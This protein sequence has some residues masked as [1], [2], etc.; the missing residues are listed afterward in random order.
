MSLVVVTKDTRIILKILGALAI[1]SVL[2][3]LLFRGGQFIQ[4]AFFPKPPAPAE[5][6][7]GILPEIEF[8]I[9]NNKGYEYRVETISGFLPTFPLTTTVYKLKRQDATI[10]ALPDAKIKAANLG[11]TENEQAL[12]TS[13][14][15]WTNFTL[16]TTLFYEIYNL[17]FSVS[18]TYSN[19]ADFLPIGDTE[20]ESLTESV[21]Q[22]IS[23]LGGNTE[24]ID[25]E[26]TK[27]SYLLPSPEGVVPVADPSM[28]SLAKIDYF[29]KPIN[30]LNI[31]YP[32]A[33]GSSLYFILAKIE[34]TP[35]VVEASYHHFVPNLSENSTYY[36]KT[37]QEAYDALS[38]GDG[39]I[40]NSTANKSIGITDVLL[41][42][43]LDNRENQ[44]YLLPIVVFK[45]LDNFEAY[46][47]AIRNQ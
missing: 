34:R 20:K 28:A 24:D 29:Q 7:F 43:Y 17:N 11:Y 5:E 15:K 1:L 16:D 33:N 31:Y 38:N 4:N 25:T 19:S 13:E 23:A 37:A 39:Y 12:S 41:G 44:E 36:I 47:P 3:F 30:E 27:F 32:E 40:V 42:Y 45:G 10:T 21:N 18:S 2:I 14:Y 22:F 9:N 35:E 46:V 26:K 6:K 8:P